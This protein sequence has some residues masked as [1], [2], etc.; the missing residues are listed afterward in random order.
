MLWQHSLSISHI[1]DG[2][3]KKG[4]DIWPRCQI[5]LFPV[6][7]CY[8]ASRRSLCGNRRSSLQTE[9]LSWV[10]GFYCSCFI[11]PARHRHRIDRSGEFCIYH[12]I[13][14]SLRR[15]EWRNKHMDN[16][17]TCQS[18]DFLIMNQATAAVVN[19]MSPSDFDLFLHP[20]AVLPYGWFHR[21][22]SANCGKPPL[23]AGVSVVSEDY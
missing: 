21:F 22:V 5:W 15:R 1:W 19:V 16:Y 13:A 23:A 7:V 11:F 12:L 10:S 2:C 4:D 18:Y 14:F 20:Y 17:K 9:G 6:W 3:Q 8:V